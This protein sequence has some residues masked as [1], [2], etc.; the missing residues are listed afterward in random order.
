MFCRF[1]FGTK[2]NKIY[3]NQ[4]ILRGS[5]AEVGWF[6]KKWLLTLTLTNLL[7]SFFHFF[8]HIAIYVKDPTKIYKRYIKI[9]DSEFADFDIFCSSCY[10]NEIYKTFSLRKMQFRNYGRKCLQNEGPLFSKYG[11]LAP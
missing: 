9:Q 1:H 5:L 6:L 3:Q 8:N 7:F 2:M 10:K 4:Q 11:F